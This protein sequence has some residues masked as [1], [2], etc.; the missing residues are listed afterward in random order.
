[1]NANGDKPSSP[2][3]FSNLDVSAA[4]DD[5]SDLLEEQGAKNRMDD[6]LR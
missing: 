4:L 2:V 5:V 3:T 1:M 6:G